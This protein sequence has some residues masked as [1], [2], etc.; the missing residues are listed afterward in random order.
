MTYR[1]YAIERIAA[2]LAILLL[3]ASLAFLLLH[4]IGMRGATRN[5]DTPARLAR[6]HRFEQ[7]SF[8]DYLW[9]L[10]GH[11]SLG[12]DLYSG[13]SLNEPTFALAPVTLSLAGAAIVFALMIGVPLGLAWSRRPRLVRP[14][15]STFVHLALALFPIWV[16]LL[17][18][19]WLGYR[20]GLLPIAGYCNFFGAPPRYGCSG[21]IQW[22]Y[23]LILPSI[24][25][26][27]VLAAV[28]TEVTR[29]LVRRV[30]RAE[31]KQ[32]ARR[33]ALIAA[34]K[35]IARNACWLVGA[36]VFVESIF[37][38][39]GLAQALIASVNTSDLAWAQAILL[40]AT[41]VAV[42]LALVVDLVAATFVRDWRTS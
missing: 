19:F 6:Y 8:G 1:R 15:G 11:G 34:A 28:Y 36:T 3:A 39:G 32:A 10:V 41:I 23:H 12:R 9:Q 21:H 18:S 5:L 26:G 27:L 25:L 40:V 2:S 42:G 20:A 7:Q 22:A 4:V 37:N 38:L 35:L 17:I 13:V 16:G 30:A 29:R 33:S 14:F 31:D 24:T